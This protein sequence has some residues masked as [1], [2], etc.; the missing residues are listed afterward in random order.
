MA[1]EKRVIDFREVMFKDNELF[2][3][4]YYEYHENGLDKYECSYRDGL[5]HGMEWMFDEYGMAIEV[6][7]YKKGEMTTFEEYYPSG[8]LKQKIELKDEMKNGIEMAFEENHNILYYGLNKDDKRYGEW[9]FYKNGKLEKY[10][11]YKNGEIIKEEKQN[12]LDCTMGL[13]G[14]SILLS[15][16]KHNVTSLENAKATP[17]NANIPTLINIFFLFMS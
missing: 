12:I 7:T 8:A 15:Y 4:I 3:G 10:V 17:N 13:A 1:F 14:D 5:K 16:Y 6:R 2:T 11:S 9:Q